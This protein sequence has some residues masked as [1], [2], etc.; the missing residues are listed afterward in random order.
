MMIIFVVTAV[1]NTAYK[2]LDGSDSDYTKKFETIPSSIKICN[3]GSS[4]GLYGFNY[5]AVKEID[6]FNFALTSQTLSYDRRL[7][8]Y[9]KDKIAQN[10]V[11]F[12]PISYFSFF[13][14][15]ER[16]EDA[17]EEKNKRY[18]R[19]LPPQ[20]IKNYDLKTDIY[21]NNLPALS[22][23]EN[24]IKGL[25][26]R[27]ENTND[28]IWSK[29]ASDRNVKQEAEAAYKRHILKNKFDK[30]GNRIINREE[31]D[32]LV[33][34]IKRCQD[35]GATPVLITTPFLKEY[36]DEIRKKDVGF[37]DEFYGLMN[38]IVTEAQGGR[39]SEN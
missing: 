7:F 16:M 23:G 29:I 5:E 24:L 18:Y 32:A 21:V 30:N 2:K 14:N 31:I 13:G 20:M 8:D 10:A 6:C 12:F 15:D 34:M 27:Y 39:L 37:F 9:Y 17:F 3:F 38:E 22:A 25:W 33:Y 28:E 11:V 19:I 4:H 26:N 36:T 35:I 1:I